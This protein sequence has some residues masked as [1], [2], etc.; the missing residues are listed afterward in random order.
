MSSCCGDLPND[1]RP[2]AI[3]RR[4]ILKGVGPAV[5]ATPYLAQAATG[6]RLQIGFCSQFLCAPPYLTASSGE[7]FK[8]EGLD[9][10]IVYLRGSPSVVQALA[11]GALGCVAELV[12]I[13]VGG[14]SSGAR[15]S[16]Q[17]ARSMH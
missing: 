9:V 15:L 4:Q 10:E 8:R 7:F 6:K 5:L 2:V 11:G 13:D 14:I 17:A 3:G 12:E 1:P 16:R